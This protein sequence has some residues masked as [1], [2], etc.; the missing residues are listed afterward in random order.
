MAFRG[1]ERPMVT[2][3]VQSGDVT[4]NSGMI[5]ARTERPSQILVEVSTTEL[6]DVVQETFLIA[7][8]KLGDFERGR[9]S[10]WLFRIAANV[11]STRHRRRRIHDAFFAVFGRIAGQNA[12]K[13]R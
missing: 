4:A 3:G 6:D 11:V 5:W 9:F 2:H 7:F 12:A 13:A 8:R 10:T 1:A